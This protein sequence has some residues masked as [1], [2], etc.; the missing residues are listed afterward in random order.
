M[1][2]TTTMTRKVPVRTALRALA[3]EQDG[4]FATAQ[5]KQLGLSVSALRALLRTGEICHIRRGVH[6]FVAVPGDPNPVVTAW[7]ACWPHGVVS[8]ESAAVWH[9]LRRVS[10]P[11]KP[12]VTVPHGIRREP[13]GVDVRQTRDLDDRDIVQ[14]GEVRYMSLDRTVCD[15]ADPSDV[16]ESLSLLDDAVAQGT[17]PRRIHRRAKALAHGRAGVSI[18]R[19]A[20]EP[21]GAA[22]FRS[23][24]ERVAAHVYRQAGLPEPEWNVEVR[25]GSGL[26]GIVDALWLPWQV[27]SEKEGMRFH[28]TPRQRRADARRFNRLGDAGYTIRRFS[29]EDVVR[30]PVEVAATVCRALQAAGADVDP[31]R[32][33]RRIEIPGGPF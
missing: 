29:W 1:A 17:K 30:T 31:A 2:Y 26:I 32:I 6:R 7:L 24:L 13:S 23:W 15:L 21:G 9:G 16:W 27:I 4:Q 20:T 3:A 5:A 14:A 25:D 8:H 28:T 11:D 10:P 18:I 19:D 12:V 22:V 33:P